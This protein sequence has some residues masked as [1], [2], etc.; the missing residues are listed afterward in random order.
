MV[1]ATSD[2]YEIERGLNP[3]MYH[4]YG[5]PGID[6]IFRVYAPLLC[7][8]KMNGRR[9]DIPVCHSPAAMHLF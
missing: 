4:S 3:Q 7:K 6:G 1:I 9:V 8:T 2:G 5:A